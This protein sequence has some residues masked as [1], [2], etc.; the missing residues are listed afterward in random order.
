MTSFRIATINTAKGD[1]PYLERLDALLAGLSDLDLDI[2]ALQEVLL[3][4]D[5]RLDTARVLARGLGMACAYVPARWKRRVVQGRTV[6]TWSGLALLSRLPIA[7]VATRPLPSTDR[8][9]E[10]RVLLTR[11]SQGGVCLR[12][13][14]THLTHLRDAQQVRR[15]QLT[16]VLA[17][18]WWHGPASIRLL[19]GDLNAGPASDELIAV[20]ERSQGWHVVD[21]YSAGGGMPRSSV[22]IPVTASP[23][24]FRIDHIWSLAPSENA[25]PSFSEARVA[26]TE[27]AA[28]GVLPSDHLAVAVTVQAP[29]TVLGPAPAT[30]RRAGD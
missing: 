5:G 14:N 6:A 3:S 28:N 4:E 11:V 13:A 2:I 26:L 1:G 23:G 20:R 17:E 24:E 10:R 18:S 27:P 16:A 30:Q 22:R 7:D 15:V 21:A 12:I 25:Q 9:G 8:D 19:C 29:V